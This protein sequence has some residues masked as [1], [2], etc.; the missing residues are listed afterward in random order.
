MKTT[1]SIDTLCLPTGSGA[2]IRVLSGGL[3]SILIYEGS[4]ECAKAIY[5]SLQRLQEL[6]VDLA[7]TEVLF[8]ETRA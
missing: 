1:I 5:L 2:S 7:E 6:Q 8:S 4:I 3:D